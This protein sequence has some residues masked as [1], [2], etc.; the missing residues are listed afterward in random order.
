VEYDAL[1][2][3]H[4]APRRN[5]VALETAR[6]RRTPVEWRAEDLATPAFTGVR[7]LE[8]FPLGILR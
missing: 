8:E 2:K 6:A 4:A 7:V 3:A 5:V 1:R